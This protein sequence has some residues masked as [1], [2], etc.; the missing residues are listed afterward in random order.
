[1]VLGIWHQTQKT[2]NRPRRL[3]KQKLLKKGAGPLQ[4]QTLVV[5]RFYRFTSTALSKPNRRNS[6]VARPRRFRSDRFEAK[7]VKE[8]MA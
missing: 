3:S 2:E 5:L 8:K 1:M 7:T 6:E 4:A